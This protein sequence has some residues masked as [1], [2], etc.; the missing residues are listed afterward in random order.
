MAG[1]SIPSRRATSTAKRVVRR[2]LLMSL[3]REG[4][5]PPDPVAGRRGTAACADHKRSVNNLRAGPQEKLR[6][7]TGKEGLRKADRNVCLP[8]CTT[9]RIWLVFPLRRLHNNKPRAV[10]GPASHLFD[11]ADV[12]PRVAKTLPGIP[13]RLTPPGEAAFVQDQNSRRRI[14]LFSWRRAADRNGKISHTRRKPSRSY[15]PV[16]EGLENRWAPAM[17]TVTTTA[18]DLTPLDGSV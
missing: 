8:N 12:L 1:L 16:L 13:T 3:L 18:D 11:P 5:W 17:V 9:T 4:N 15:R 10:E 7:K 14:M 6:K 2:G